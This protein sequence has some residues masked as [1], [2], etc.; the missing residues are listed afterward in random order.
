MLLSMLNRVQLGI[1]RKQ[2]M[3]FALLQFMLLLLPQ[4]GLMLIE[5][6]LV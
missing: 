3:F 2:L 1:I 4:L 6:T 5:F